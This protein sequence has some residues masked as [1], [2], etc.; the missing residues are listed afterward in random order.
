LQHPVSPAG[1]ADDS[2]W[3]TVAVASIF[4][5]V[6][7]V[8]MSVGVLAGRQRLRGSCGGLAMLD[9]PEADPKCAICSTP[10]KE[11]REL[12]KALRRKQQET[13]TPGAE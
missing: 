3:R 8:A 1:Q 12:K 5:A 6:A 11:C 4:F 10:A 2:F 9:D 13:E 7:I